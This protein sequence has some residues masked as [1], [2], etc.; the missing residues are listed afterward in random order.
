MMPS[1]TVL[2]LKHKVSDL[3]GIDV[4]QQKL[5]LTGKTLAGKEPGRRKAQPEF[6]IASIV[7]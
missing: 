6:P 4:P 1:E 7:I 3:L 5:L 2:Q